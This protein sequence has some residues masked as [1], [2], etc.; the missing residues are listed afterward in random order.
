MFLLCLILRD[1][2]FSLRDKKKR[3]IFFIY[4]STQAND[5]IIIIF[6]FNTKYNAHVPIFLKI[7]IFNIIFSE[8]E[9]IKFLSNLYLLI[10]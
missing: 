10:C 8:V 5:L 2:I 7:I 4:E 6:N 9:H 3:R 1:K